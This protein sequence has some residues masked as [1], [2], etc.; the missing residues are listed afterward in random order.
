MTAQTTPQVVA[1]RFLPW[2]RTGLAAH[3]TEAAVNGLA[4]HDTAEAS[5]SLSLRSSGAAGERVDLP[6]VDADGHHPGPHRRPGRPA[7]GDRT[8]TVRRNI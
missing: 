7:C 5:A 2:L 4:Q 3:I 8:D 6:V 1:P